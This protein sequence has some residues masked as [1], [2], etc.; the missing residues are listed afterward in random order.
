MKVCLISPPSPE[1]IEPL[2]FPPLGLLYV[3]SALDQYSPRLYSIDAGD[4]VPTDCDVYGFT[5]TTSQSVWVKKAIS[6]IRE[7]NPECYT[8]VGGP[9]PTLTGENCGADCCFIGEAELE[10]ED[11]VRKRQ[12]GRVNAQ[13]P[14]DLDTIRLPKRESEFI[15]KYSC[16]L[17]GK[18]ATSMVTTRGC[19][20]SCSYCCSVNKPV[21]F[22][23][24]ISV[25]QEAKQIK[26]LGYECI[27]FYDD[28]FT[29]R[30]KRLKK[31]CEIL[32]SLALQWKCL[33]R[34]DIID[35]EMVKW[36]AEAGCIEVSFGVES[37]SQQILQNVNRN[38]PTERS[39]EAIRACNERGI[40]TRA[41]FI[42]GLPGESWQS[43]EETRQ[44][45][46]KAR[47]TT[48]NFSLFMPYPGSDIFENPG[49]YDIYFDK[50]NILRHP[51]KLWYQRKFQN[52]KCI[53]S[54][55]KMSS[56]EILRAR[57]LL[58]EEFEEEKKYW[59]RKQ[60]EF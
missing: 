13:K 33:S 8:V 41:F 44:F 28:I 7:K 57:G 30:K 47:P 19:P 40:R 59:E 53:V 60:C 9:H 58:S 29:L 42:V 17:A 6:K 2:V 43:I 56:D 27:V 49:K 5:C 36:M 38:V 21:R 4:K 54:T 14:Q 10:I 50:Q 55:S 12:K 20:F 1:L 52:Y 35:R 48:V 15:S 25:Y 23:S 22:R 37:G 45:I 3:A 18:K 32:K 51:E 16:F 26:E 39:I 11:V 24:P 34:G 31:I 46:L